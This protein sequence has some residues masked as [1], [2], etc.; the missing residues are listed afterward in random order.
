MSANIRERE[1]N[2]NTQSQELCTQ[3]VL[4]VYNVGQVFG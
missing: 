4:N 3:I 1:H 2:N